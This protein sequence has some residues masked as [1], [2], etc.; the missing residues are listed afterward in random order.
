M[1]EVLHLAN[2]TRF[3]EGA[4]NKVACGISEKMTI[5]D[6]LAKSVN[7]WSTCVGNRNVATEVASSYLTED[8]E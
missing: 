2:I 5:F 7:T 8:D 4:V 6:F 3:F 1:N